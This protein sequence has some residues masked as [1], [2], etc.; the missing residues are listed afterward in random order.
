MP[1]VTLEEAQARLPELI[2]QLLP[3]E[4][5]VI[6]RNDQPIAAVEREVPSQAKPRLSGAREMVISTVGHRRAKS[7]G[8]ALKLAIRH[9]HE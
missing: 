5:F 3:G 1:T 6:T 9:A 8:A 2:E 4:R 7:N